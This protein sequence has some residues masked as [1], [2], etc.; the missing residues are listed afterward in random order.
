[1]KRK[2]IVTVAIIFCFVAVTSTIAVLAQNN[3]LPDW[4]K[5]KIEIQDK[6]KN[7][8]QDTQSRY[9]ETKNSD[10][11]KL[12]SSELNDVKSKDVPAFEQKGIF[13]VDKIILP[14]SSEEQ[15]NYTL[16]NLGYTPHDLVVVGKSN[17]NANQGVILDFYV[18]PITWEQKSYSITID[19][20]GTIKLTKVNDNFL[21]FESENGITG[22]YDVK[23]HSL[24]K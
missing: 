15:K 12:T 7:E 13:S 8:L 22:T 18:A 10:V 9:N 4:V 1:M 20:S 2:L 6:M 3:V 5:N 14:L 11:K 19:N 21:E 23:T 24:V 17:I 16:Y